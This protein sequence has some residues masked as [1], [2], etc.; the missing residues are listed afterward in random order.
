MGDRLK[1]KIAVVTGA[2]SGVGKQDALLF[3]RE[4]ARVV[5]TDVNEEAGREVAAE[6]E[7]GRAHV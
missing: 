3:A 5:L 6:I 7:I 4:G 1:G 2:A